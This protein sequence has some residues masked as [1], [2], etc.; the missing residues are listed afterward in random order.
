MTPRT[1]RP[2]RLLSRASESRCAHCPPERV[3]A[4]ACVQGAGVEDILIGAV[5]EQSQNWALE[6][7]NL[8]LEETNRAL[9][10]AFNG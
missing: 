9:W 1:E 6:R 7:T 5:L 10:D 3:C 2:V 4:W 8:G